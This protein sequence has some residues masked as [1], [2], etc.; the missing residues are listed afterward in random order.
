MGQRGIC[1]PHLRFKNV[2]KRDIRALDIITE[3]WEDQHLKM[4]QTNIMLIINYPIML[5]G[6][7]TV[8]GSFIRYE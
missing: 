6:T 8:V 7:S 3:S 2:C 1:P 4:Q 5:D